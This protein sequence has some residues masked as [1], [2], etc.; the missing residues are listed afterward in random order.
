MELST[1]PA[2]AAVPVGPWRF[3]ASLRQ[4]ASQQGVD[5][6]LQLVVDLSI[7]LVRGCD[8]AD[9]MLV[10][11]S[12]VITPVA[13]DPVAVLLDRAQVGSGEGPC[14]HVAGDGDRVVRVGDLASDLRW[15]VFGPRASALGVRSALSFEL[16]F[17]DGRA[18]RGGAL[19]LYG[20]AREAF[21]DGAVR[22]GEVFADQCATV[23]SAAIEIEGL[24]AAL[25]SRDTIGQA[26]GILMERFNI[27][28]AEA[29][30]LL[31]G[32]SETRN[33]K[34]K[35]VAELVVGQRRLP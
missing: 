21:D 10:S 17:E 5:E 9:V 34:L 28:G 22:L 33:V 27:D 6:A 15:P 18:S 14:L 32:A 13:T 7:E 1:D 2:G 11:P 19:N 25:A 31:K 24:H 4:L 12:G 30:G 8:L 3:A 16:L 26:K 23:M 35:Q 29:F 20:H